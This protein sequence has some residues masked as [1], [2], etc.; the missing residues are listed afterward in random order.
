MSAASRADQPSAPVEL[1]VAR[2]PIFQSDR[3]LAGYELLFR[4]GSQNI[5][6]VGVDPDKASKEIIGQTLSVFGLEALVGTK[7]AYVN[8]T[9]KVLVD[10][11]YAAL[12]AERLVLELLET[13]RPDP[14]TLA[15]CR[16]A[17]A[18]G[19][20]I[21]LDDYVDQPELADFLPLCDVIK[22]DF[23]SADAERRRAIAS[24]Y[25]GTNQK[26]LAEKIETEEDFVSARDL[27]F[28]YF[29][30]FFFCRPE[31]LSRTDIPVSKLVYLQF[32]SE[33][34]RRELD[35][36]RIEQVIKQDVALS[37]KLLRYLKAAAFGWR[38]EIT[39]IK[40][41]LAM[42]GERPFRRWA[43]VLVM[44]ALS[45]DRPAEL[46]S[47]CL[48]R[49]RFCEQ[50]APELDLKARELDLFVLGLFSLMDAVIG[51]PLSELLSDVAL[52]ADLQEALLPTG[53][54][55]RMSDVLALVT[56][57]ERADWRNVDALSTR[58]SLQNSIGTLPRF[59][60]EALAW[61]TT[62]AMAGRS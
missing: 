54:T 19:Y 2:Q 53:K 56:A 35:F 5:F 15:A 8:V 55:N 10:A 51:R 40:Q 46:L 36:K 7:L 39:S 6:P 37:V 1:F 33:L 30:G 48:V 23:R 16:A 62:T 29:Q 42:L 38:T 3:T 41:A 32:L 31:M 57:Y 45:S 12:P 11:T 27:G 43:S 50:L 25:A 59:Y 22:V 52:P 58:L 44:A 47:T 18:A 9:R 28:N 60:Q 20:Q 26:L 14:E 49:A 21:A 34:N 61:A 13:L 17:K 4:T 24:R